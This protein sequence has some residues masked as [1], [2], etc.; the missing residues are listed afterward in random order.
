MTLEARIA[1]AV[2]AERERIAGLVRS[3]LRAAVAGEREAC[4][5]LADLE[6]PAIAVRI[7]AR[8]AP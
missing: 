8:G 4:A 6:F 5:A 3:Q 1:D 7:R 2:I